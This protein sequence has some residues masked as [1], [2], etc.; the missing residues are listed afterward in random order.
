MIYIKNLKLIN[1]KQLNTV[2]IN[3]AKRVQFENLK[4]KRRDRIQAIE[5]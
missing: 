3:K 1:I 5:K 2:I 4:K